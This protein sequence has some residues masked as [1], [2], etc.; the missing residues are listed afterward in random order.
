MDRE[1]IV[2]CLEQIKWKRYRDGTYSNSDPY[3]AV[4][5]KLY[6]MRDG[7]DETLTKAELLL[8]FQATRESVD[9]IASRDHLPETL[10]EA[11]ELKNRLHAMAHGGRP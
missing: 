6:H 1:T 5:G 10:T 9:Y 2:A 11:M 4:K 3:V 7:G 8:L